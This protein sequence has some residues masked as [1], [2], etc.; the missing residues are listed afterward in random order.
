MKDHSK[1]QQREYPFSPIV[2]VGVLVIRDKKILLVKRGQPPSI[3]K[4]T[5]PGGLV[6]LGE[7]TEEAAVRELKEECNIVVKITEIIDVFDYIEYD[8]NGQTRFHYVIIDF[9]GTYISG[10]LRAGGDVVAAEWISYDSLQTLDIPE[11]TLAFIRKA[12]NKS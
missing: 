9:L 5:V 11:K 10:T 7:R 6:E 3:G 8:K 1:Q 2:G 4:W 12:I